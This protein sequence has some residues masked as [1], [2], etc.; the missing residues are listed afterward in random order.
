MV[1][2]T[3]LILG[4]YGNAGKAIAEL[5]LKESEAC[6]ILAYN[7]GSMRATRRFAYALFAYL[8]RETRVE[9]PAELLGNNFQPFYLCRFCSFIRKI[10]AVRLS[11]QS[12]RQL[13]K[14]KKRERI[15]DEKSGGRKGVG[16]VKIGSDI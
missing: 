10:D 11:E 7:G 14:R 12:T 6:I 9:S 3:V 13:S 15:F 16:G 1:C 2:K 4:G 8:P 5:L